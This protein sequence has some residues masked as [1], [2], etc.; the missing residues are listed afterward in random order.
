[1]LAVTTWILAAGALVDAQTYDL[2][3]SLPRVRPPRR[4][5]PRL[6][7]QGGKGDDTLTATGAF[8]ELDVCPAS[9][10]PPRLTSFSSAGRRRR[11]LVHGQRLRQLRHWVRT[12]SLTTD[13]D[14]A[15]HLG[16]ERASPPPPPSYAAAPRGARTRPFPTKKHRSKT[17]AHA[18]S[19]PRSRKL[20]TA[21]S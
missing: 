17:I 9:S 13:V 6:L 21:R 8:V 14:E 20:R 5:R 18:P 3:R 19:A 11:R 10:L 7:P 16:A 1:M 15:V 2:P 12:L 4:A